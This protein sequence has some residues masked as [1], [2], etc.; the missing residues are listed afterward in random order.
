MNI[1]GIAVPDQ[2]FST[3]TAWIWIP[4]LPEKERNAALKR[5]AINMDAAFLI[6]STLQLFLFLYLTLH[7]LLAYQEQVFD[8]LFRAALKTGDDSATVGFFMQSG[9]VNLIGYLFTFRG[10]LLT[11]AFGDA[12]VR[13]IGYAVSKEPLGTIFSFVPIAL[14][15]FIVKQWDRLSERMQFGPQAPDEIQNDPQGNFEQIIILSARPKNWNPA[16]TVRYR[17]L[18]YHPETPV[19]VQHGNY[20][21]YSYRLVRQHEHEMIRRLIVYQN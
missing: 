7:S 13:L 18:D 12:V 20:F 6:S 1:G 16:I 8:Q 14:F 9:L 21:R 2:L 3:L 10:F 11:L 15:R 5:Y 17:G 4:V 19:R